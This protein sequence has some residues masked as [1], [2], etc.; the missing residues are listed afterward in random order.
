MLVII[1]F[2]DAMQLDPGKSAR[3]QLALTDADGN[4]QAADIVSA[5]V[6]DLLKEA[7]YD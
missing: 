3:L 6:K 5:P 1:P 2:T 7:G 4:P